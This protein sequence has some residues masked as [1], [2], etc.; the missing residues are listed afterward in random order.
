[1]I[2]LTKYLRPFIYSITAAIL[3]LFLQAACDLSLPYYMS[4]IVNVGIQQNGVQNSTP[5]AIS[6]DGYEFITM[7]MSHDQRALLDKSYSLRSGRDTDQDGVKYESIYPRALKEKIY[8]LDE[9]ISQETRGQL[10]IIFGTSTQVMINVLKSL[11]AAEPKEIDTSMDRRD[12]RAMEM[13]Q[14]YEMKGELEGLPRSTYEMERKKAVELDDAVLSQSGTMLAAAL[15]GELGVDIAAFQRAYIFGTGSVMLFIALVSGGAIV[16]VGFFS[17]R[18]AAG[19]ARDLRGEIFKAVSGFSKKEFNRFSTASLITRSTNDV[20]QIQT[21][22]IVGIRM[23]CYAPIM[24][25]G[26]VFMA[27]KKSA[28]MGWIIALAC[29]LI[30]GLILVAF[31]IVIPKFKAVQKLID[32]LSLV[33]RETLSGLMVIRAFGKSQYEEGRFD[34]ANK[35]LTETTLFVNRVVSFMMPAMTLI[36]NGASILIIWVG[37]HNVAEAGIQVGDMMAFMQYAMQI[38]MSFL[39]I[40]MMFLFIPRASVSAGRIVEVLDTEPGIKDPLIAKPMDETKRGHVEFKNVHFRY[41]D[42]AKDALEDISFTAKPG[43]ITAFIGPTGAGKSTLVNL[44][45]RFYDVT[46]GQVLVNGVD[47]KD[48]T[49]RKLRSLM[50]YVPQKSVL[51]SGT[52]ED[53]I[54]FGNKHLTEG[55]IRKIAEAAQALDFISQRE[56]GFGWEIS[57]GGANVSGGQRQR[58]AIA[59]ALA[60]RPDIYIFDDSF[61][62]LDYR[63]DAALRRALKEFTGESTV[64]IVA[65]RVSTIMDADQIFC[66]EDGRIVGYGT[67]GELLSSCPQYGE[68]VSSQHIRG[69]RT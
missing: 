64:I 53:N 29:I 13:P 20:M 37:A 22:L 48:L 60:V 59:R 23:F 49:Q 28:S 36:M 39:M 32:G 46:G 25:A 45:P 5:H 69:E 2:K 52:I 24:A 4:N 65:Q 66:M 56:G 8:I 26:G 31:S 3:L 33:A 11:D 15:Y 42:A 43:E 54:K 68:I 1:M 12:I 30:T 38:I 41:D 7:F 27:L 18:I 21:L 67:H 14:L 17:S 10:D 61:S 50:G 40:S 44:I 19:V 35:D 16:L 62:A 55:E 57:Q 47:V 63:T 34:Q 51:M 58:L 6:R 9:D